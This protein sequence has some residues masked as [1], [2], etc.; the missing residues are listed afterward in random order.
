MQPLLAPRTSIARHSWRLAILIALVAIPFALIGAFV[1][2]PTAVIPLAGGGEVN[3]WAQKIFYIHVPIAFAAY[4][5]FAVGAWNAVLYLWH[6]TPDHDVR[7]YVG[8]HVGMVFGT[9]VLITGSIWAKAAWGVWWQWGDRQLL[10][11]LILYLFYGAYFMLRFSIPAGPSRATASA[12]TALVG[13]ALVPM[14]FLAIRIADSLIHPVVIDS[15]GLNMTSSMAVV[16]LVSSIGFIALCS[17]MIQF[18]VAAK[19]LAMRGWVATDFD[20]K[21]IATGV[22]SAPSVEATSH[23]Q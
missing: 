20:T 8:I 19:L 11:F 10:V 4:W 6:R 1:W 5:G 15:E 22:T 9:L 14:S 13:V 3:D 23:G 16:F 2:A 7:S 17:A 12:A 21:A 18:E